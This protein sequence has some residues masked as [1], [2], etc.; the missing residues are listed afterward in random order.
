MQS[1]AQV[2]AEVWTVGGDGVSSKNARWKKRQKDNRRERGSESGA[3]ASG[4]V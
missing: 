1:V 4:D 3:K 2:A